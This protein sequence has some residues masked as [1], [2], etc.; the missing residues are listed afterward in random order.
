VL[1]EH[2]IRRYKLR[3]TRPRRLIIGVDTTDDETHGQQELAFYNGHYAH[4][5]YRYLFTYT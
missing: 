1:V 3:F 4:H 5:C 2:F